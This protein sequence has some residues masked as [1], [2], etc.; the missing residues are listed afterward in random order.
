MSGEGGSSTTRLRL[1]MEEMRGKT[2][3]SI[4]EDQVKYIVFG[5]RLIIDTVSKGLHISHFYY[6]HPPPP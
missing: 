4:Q 2:N 3:A 5:L 1:D 6:D